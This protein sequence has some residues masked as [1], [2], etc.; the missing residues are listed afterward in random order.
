MSPLAAL[1]SEPKEELQTRSFEPHR[2]IRLQDDDVYSPPSSSS[3]NAVM[4]LHPR[5]MQPAVRT[6]SSSSSQTL[7]SEILDDKNSPSALER[8]RS[9]SVASNKSEEK[10]EKR[11]RSRVTPEQLQHLERFFLLDRNPTAARRREISKLLGMQE[12]QTQIWFQNRR[13]KAKLPD[14]RQQRHKRVTVDIPPLDSPPQLSASIQIDLHNLIHEDD[15][16]T[17]IPCTELTIGSWR[18]MATMAAKHDLV[19]Y[20]SDIKRCLIWYIHSDGFGFKMEIPFNTVLETRLTS[21]AP[22]SGLASFLLS[23]PPL[24]YLENIEPMS[25]D[26]NPKR[27]WKRGPDWTEGQQ[28]SRILRHDLIGSAP[29]LSHLLLNLRNIRNQVPADFSVRQPSYPLD[30]T[31]RSTSPVMPL[32]LPPPPLASLQFSGSGSRY[33]E[34]EVTETSVSHHNSTF[35]HRSSYVD[36]GVTPSPDT[37]YSNEGGRPPPYDVPS[38][39]PFSFA[40]QQSHQRNCQ[41]TSTSFA[42]DDESSYTAFE[43]HR[44][45]PRSHSVGD[46]S[47]LPISHGLAPRPY[48][49]QA[50]PRSFYNNISY[51]TSQPEMQSYHTQG[52]ESRIPRVSTPSSATSVYTMHEQLIHPHLDVRHQQH[53]IVRASPSPPLLTTPYHPP[54]HLFNQAGHTN[55]MDSGSSSLNFIYSGVDYQA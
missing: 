3:S 24:F 9:E 51:L 53:I 41:P 7:E 31:N 27:H 33:P 10:V 44:A 45:I 2:S 29:Q 37:P 54:P 48:S 17:I 15:T 55:H 25:T 42:V 47:E 52:E 30:Q 19:A 46:F 21:V 8:E 50:I 23:E 34:H 20:V 28:A 18:R 11:K 12:R 39:M 40:Q 14:G 36:P 38:T 43:T 1:S 49:V 35:K 26:G 13:A 5:S 16:V 6:L 22:E 32:D 4:E